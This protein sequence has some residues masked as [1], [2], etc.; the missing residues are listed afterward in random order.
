MTHFRVVH[1]YTGAFPGREK[2]ASYGRFEINCRCSFLSSA[3]KLISPFHSIQHVVFLHVHA[4]MGFANGVNWMYL[5]A[6]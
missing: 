4:G 5:A 1:L 6:E 2:D 3:R